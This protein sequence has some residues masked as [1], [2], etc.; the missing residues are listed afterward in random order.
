MCQVAVLDGFLQIFSLAS[1]FANTWEDEVRDL[2]T[3]LREI[4][5]LILESDLFMDLTF[6]M[7]GGR[8]K[9]LGVTT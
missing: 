1:T 7:R 6:V 3:T 5:K 9:A 8:D 4:L 2:F